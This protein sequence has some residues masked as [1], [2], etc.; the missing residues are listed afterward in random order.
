MSV[1]LGMPVFRIWRPV[2]RM[3]EAVEA[4]EHAWAALGV[5]AFED[6]DSGTAEWNAAAARNRAVRRVAPAPGYSGAS[7]PLVI[8]DADTAPLSLQPLHAAAFRVTSAMDPVVL[9]Y[10]TLRAVTPEGKTVS[11]F[12]WSCGGIYVTTPYGW[13]TMGGQDERFTGWS[14]ED[15]AFRIAV[16]TRTGKPMPRAE[17]VAVSYQ[18]EP[19]PDRHPPGTTELFERYRNASGSYAAIDA[20]HGFGRK[21]R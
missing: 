18:H 14:P 8:T 3:R 2:E 1:R 9:P 21:Y 17:G 11:E 5:T 6:V 12:D 7:T 13:W 19:N 10:T 16:E 20:L 15:F 4:A